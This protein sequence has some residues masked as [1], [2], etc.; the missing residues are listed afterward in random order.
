MT[1]IA[2]LGATGNVGSRLLDEALS[3]GHRVTAL[4]RE[5]ARLA[6]RADLNVVAGDAKDPQAAKVL[7]GHDVLVSSLRFADIAPDTLIDFARATGIPRLLIVGGAASLKLPDGSRLF[8]APAFP[9]EY[10]SEAGAGIATLDALRGVSD[11][12]WVFVSPQMV[13]APGTRTGRFRLGDDTLLF[14]AAGDSHISYEDFAVALLDE[15]E[16][17]VHHRT[18]FTVGY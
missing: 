18:R 17:P 16:R 12:D 3:R 11:L 1:S 2:L 15:V 8:D 14:D 13:F 9:A 10:R 7:S 6:S 4:V 5:P